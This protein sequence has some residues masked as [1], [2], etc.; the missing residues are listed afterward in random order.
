MF[1]EAYWMSSVYGE[2]VAIANQ[3]S[4]VFVYSFDHV[5]TNYRRQSP[6]RAVVQG[7]YVQYLL[8]TPGRAPGAAEEDTF[9]PIGSDWIVANLYGTFIANFV[10][11]GSGRL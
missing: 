4:Q 6:Y 2:A 10:M 3:G 5:S 1:T 11:T 8:S 9:A 7:A